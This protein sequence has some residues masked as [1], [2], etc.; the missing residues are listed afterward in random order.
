MFVALGV[1]I[2][3][4]STHIIGLSGAI[5]SPM[6]FPVLLAGFVCGGYYGIICGILSP[7]LS[8]LITGMP[9]AWPLL[10]VMTAELVAYG[11]VSALLYRKLKLP[12]YI[13]LPAAMVAG[14]AVYGLLFVIFTSLNPALNLMGI[15]A[16]ITMGLPGIALQL[17]LIPVI[18]GTLGLREKLQTKVPLKELEM[19]GKTVD[20]TIDRPI[21]AEHPKHEGLIYPINYGFVEGLIAGD[22]EEQDV[23]ILGITEPLEKFSGKI[24]AI[25][26]RFNDVENKWV[27]APDGKSY[28]KKEI[29]EAV[30][31]QEKYYKTEVITK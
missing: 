28:T 23:Y 9:P 30:N 26:K 19:I 4:F 12:I 17:F 8:M 3:M 5:L 29:E 10:P 21:G 20:V 18:I 14:R 31:F 13:A 11:A 7:V 25:I 24:I 15:W 6:H 1:L 2:P 16:A 27:A 22:G